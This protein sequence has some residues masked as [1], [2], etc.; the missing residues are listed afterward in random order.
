[1]RPGGGGCDRGLARIDARFCPK[2]AIR[3]SPGFQPREP[4]KPHRALQG[5]KTDWSEERLKRVLVLAHLSTNEYRLALSEIERNDRVLRRPSG[6]SPGVWFLGLKP[7]AES[8]SPF[9]PRK[10]RSKPKQTKLS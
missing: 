1:M 2:G 10:P 9:G 3:L 8:C 6:G 4:A 7:Q 5:R